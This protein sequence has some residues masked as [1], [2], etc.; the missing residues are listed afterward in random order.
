M[1]SRLSGYAWLSVLT[2]VLTLLLKGEAY[3]RSQSV[4]VLSDALESFVNLAAALLALAMLRWAALPPD[5]DHAF[6]HE[7]AEYISA[8]VEGGLILVA[9]GGILTSALPRL[10]NPQPILDWGVGSGLVALA[11]LANAA[12]ATVLLRAGRRHGSI[13][14][15]ADAGHLFSDCWSSLGVLLGVALCAWTGWQILDPLIA[16][17]VA[18][19]V[20]WTGFSILGRAIHGVLDA[21]LPP[22]QL[23]AI[24]RLLDPYRRDGLDFHA[25]RTRRA[26]RSCF[27]Q[28][29]V[30][31]PGEWSVSKGHDLLEEIEAKLRELVPGAR[32]H[33]HLEPLDDPA[34]FEDIHLERR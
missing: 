15:E 28:L 22:D 32:L 29:H 17:G 26:G 8:G 3:R 31:V 7:K 20:G 34:S 25:L 10:L 13:A 6:G 1:N 4:G 27:I 18:I 30:L 12:T 24:E 16:I 5:D 21:S 23:E 14:L 9:A 11:T 2:A 19:Y 33:T